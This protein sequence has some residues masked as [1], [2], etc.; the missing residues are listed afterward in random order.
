L[1]NYLPVFE[2]ITYLGQPLEHV[3]HFHAVREGQACSLLAVTIIRK[4]EDFLWASAKDLLDRSMKQAAL[5]M[6]GVHVF[7]LLTF[8]F[9]KEMKTFNFAELAQVLANTSF[10]LQPGEQRL[11]RYASVFG[12]LQ[13]MSEAH[14][15]KIVFKTSVEVFP[16]KPSFLFTLVSR[17]LKS[18]DF[19]HDPVMVLVNDLSTFPLYDPADEQ[20]K[21]FLDDLIAKQK[22]LSIDFPP[23]VYVQNRRGVRELLSGTVVK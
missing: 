7:D 3:Q 22:K 4:D 18:V 13:K 1:F 5:T 14:W 11:V 17:I 19:A 23:E 6:R 21:A 12:L 16:D 2:E 10:K 15:G 8:D 20:Q 9:H